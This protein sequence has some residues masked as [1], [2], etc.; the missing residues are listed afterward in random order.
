MSNIDWSREVVMA[1][2]SN[3]QP[4]P[5]PS[6]NERVA[7]AEEVVTAG[8]LLAKFVVMNK[9]KPPNPGDVDKPVQANINWVFRPMVAKVGRGQDK[10]APSIGSMAVPGGKK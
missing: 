2:D 3:E 8:G 10:V 1:K 7:A 9:L 4:A 6:G 5:L